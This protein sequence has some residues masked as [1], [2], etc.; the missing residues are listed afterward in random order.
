MRGG[1]DSTQMGGESRSQNS[2]FRR[3]NPAQRRH[4]H[5]GSW[6]LASGCFF[7]LSRENRSLFATSWEDPFQDHS[8]MSKQLRALFPFAL[9]MSGALAFAQSTTPALQIGRAHV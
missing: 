7:L 3:R 9:V 8:K 5:S 2:E 4:H 1:W 6:I